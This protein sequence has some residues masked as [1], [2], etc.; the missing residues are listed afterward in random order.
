MIEKYIIEVEVDI[1]KLRDMVGDT[2]SGE[3]EG[4]IIEEMGWVEQSGISIIKIQKVCL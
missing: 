2:D 1:N 3:V 4:M